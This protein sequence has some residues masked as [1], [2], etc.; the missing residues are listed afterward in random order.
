MA[1]EVIIPVK[2]VMDASDLDKAAQKLGALTAEEKKLEAEM[3]D[4]AAAGRKQAA[5]FNQAGDAGTKAAKDTEKQYNVLGNTMG[6]M[7][8]MIAGAFSVGAVLQLG[9]A[10]FAV[11]AE[12]EK[13]R[14]VLTTA[15]GSGSAAERAMLMIQEFAAK[16]PFSVAEL[17]EAYVKFANRGL[18][19]TNKEM[20]ALGDLASSTGKSFDQLTEAALD[21]MTGENERLKEFGI[22]AQRT[23]ETTQYT[24]K[25]VT[26]EVKNSSAAI[27]EY[28][29]S[30]GKVEGVSGAAAAISETLTGRISNLDDSF[31]QLFLTIG[32]QQTGVFG[33]TISL[34]DGIVNSI[35]FLISTTNQLGKKESSEAVEQYAVEITKQFTKVA[36]EAKKAGQD[37]KE[38]LDLEGF[39]KASVLKEQLIDAE[40]K[41]KNFRAFRSNVA[42][43]L[44]EVTDY[45]GFEKTKNKAIEASFAATVERIKGQ[46]SVIEDTK[47]KVLQSG[48]AAEAKA[49]DDAAK[50]AKAAAEKAAKAAED[51]FNKRDK[52]R[53]SY[54]PLST[55][56][57]DE[58]AELGDKMLAEDRKQQDKLRDQHIKA[59]TENVRIAE[60]A[61]ANEKRIAAEKEAYKQRLTDEGIEL[62]INA[63]YA[64]TQFQAAASEERIADLQAK[65]EYEQTLAGDNAEARKRIEED[66]N[67]QIAAERVK[68]ATLEKNAALFQIAIDTGSAIIKTGAELGYPAAIP[69]QIMAG[70]QG[71]IQAAIVSSKAIPRYAKGTRSVTGGTP[72]EDSV[73][74]MLMPGERVITTDKNRQLT[75][76]FDVLTNSKLPAKVWNQTLLDI[77]KFGVFNPPKLSDLQ[78]PGTAGGIDTDRIVAAVKSIVIERTTFDER[79]VVRFTEAQQSRI[80]RL[81]KRY[82]F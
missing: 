9:K 1:N 16:T 55:E 43:Q 70:V 69:F 65:S 61:A 8:S 5:A 12:F 72:G 19:L 23:G 41:L 74:A 17:T 51:A 79:G 25:G 62:A 81:N 35:T 11:T 33:E 56:Q 20:E 38:A 58:F 34:I 7:Q 21:A 31:D 4:V 14:A 18:K 73:L 45:T 13:M 80:R 71:A 66:F 22:T 76:A 6:N 54:L 39:G 48:K 57:L 68:Q 46:L 26:T 60:E 37:I 47:N 40:E 64:F 78:R 50:T 3:N 42:T 28:L 49:A 63:A 75:P 53:T 30:L 77:E 24:F 2:Y 29:I 10:V 44:S 52:S 59:A 36:T 15:L 82:G 67:K 27:N 32:S